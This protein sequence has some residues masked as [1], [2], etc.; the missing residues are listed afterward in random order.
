MEIFTTHD[1]KVRV[2][3]WVDLATF[4]PTHDSKTGC[5]DLGRQWIPISTLSNHPWYSWWDIGRVKL[6]SIAWIGTNTLDLGVKSRSDEERR[7]SLPMTEKSRCGDEYTLWIPISTMYNHLFILQWDMR[8][9]NLLWN[10]WLSPNTLDLDVKSGCGSSQHQH[11]C[12]R[13][14][15]KNR[16]QWPCQTMN[17]NLNPV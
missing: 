2:W 3:W 17:S 5:G 15:L 6:Q 16:L 10:A 11:I 7:F 14:W 9:A 1:S 8:A 4:V 12:P 13:S